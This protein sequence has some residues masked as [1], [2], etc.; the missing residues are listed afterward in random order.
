[1]KRILYTILTLMCVAEM[2]V[3]TVAPVAAATG[4]DLPWTSKDLL[5]ETILKRDGLI[6]G[7]WFP[8]FEGGSIGHGLTGN[9]VMAKYYGSSWSKVSMDSVGADR[10]YREIYNLKAMGYNILGYGGSVYDEGVIHDAYGD[11]TGIKQDYL[12]SLKAAQTVLT[13]T[14]TAVLN[15]NALP[16]KDENGVVIV[17]QY[18]KTKITYGNKQS[19][20]DETITTT[21]KVYIHKW[22]DKVENL[23]GAEFSLKKGGVVVKLIKLDEKGIHYRVAMP[24]EEG[25]VDTFVTVKEADIVIWGLDTDT[26]YTLVEIDAPD[27][28]NKLEDEVKVTVN[29]TNDSLIKVEN[30]SGTELPSTGGIGTTIF[31]ILGAALMLGAAVLLITKRRM[32]IAD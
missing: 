14:Y 12:D 18:N 13:L 3:S 28:Y 10:I 7:I 16:V 24:G 23:A 20:D 19:V 29:A 30:K 26:D 31:Y 11:V 21:H 27:G 4:G 32:N 8:W 5:I 17:D 9:D 22:A 6:D 1:M 2:L 25:A 15:E